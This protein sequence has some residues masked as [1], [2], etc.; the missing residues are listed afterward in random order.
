MK[1]GKV[2]SMF[3][4]VKLVRIGIVLMLALLSM[5][6][7]GGCASAKFIE[8]G[9]SFDAKPD[10]CHIEVFHSKLPDRDYLELGILE[11]EGFLFGDTLE[12]VLPKMKEKACRAGGDGII[13]ISSQ[14]FIDRHDD[15]NL[16]VSATVIRWTE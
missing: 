7:F 16:I 5:A 10:N 8:T 14:K 4:S 12:K 6:L 11:G 15:E 2:L 9:P 1:K 13:L 3:C